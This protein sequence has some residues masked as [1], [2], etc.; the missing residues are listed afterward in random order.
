MLKSPL[1]SGISDYDDN[2]IDNW[3]KVIKEYKLSCNEDKMWLLGP[4]SYIFSI[5]GVKFAVDPQIRRR[6]DFEKILPTLKKDF[7]D[8]SFVLITHQHGDHMCVPLINAL[9]DSNIRWY[10]PAGVRSDYIEKCDFNP[11]HLIYIKPGYLINEGNLKISTFFSPHAVG[12]QPF[13]QCGFN[14]GCDK[15]NIVITGDIRDYSYVYPE[16]SD[17]SLCIAH[18]WAGRD[19]IDEEKYLPELERFVKTACLFD[20]KRYFLCHLYEI[21]RTPESMWSYKHAGIAM[22]MFY[23]LKPLSTVEVPRVGR[24]YNIFQE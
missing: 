3:Q 8:I 2:F 23:S 13:L 5:S 12:E 9:K 17:V 4:S 18:V 14:I 7:E 19:S 10:I 6:T 1:E 11:E 24:S 21:G 15:G 22:D 20:A 16:F